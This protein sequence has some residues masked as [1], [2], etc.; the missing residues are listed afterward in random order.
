MDGDCV[1]CVSVVVK[2][3]VV[4]PCH[5]L[6]A[7]SLEADVRLFVKVKGVDI[8]AV[9]RHLAEPGEGL[10]HFRT[11]VTHTDDDAGDDL[12]AVLIGERL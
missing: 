8:Y 4:L 11:V 9:A 1:A 12:F 3:M 6:G 7:E 5:K 10:R 2:F